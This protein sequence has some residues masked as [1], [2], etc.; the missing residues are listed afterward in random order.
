MNFVGV[1]RN[2]HAFGDHRR[3]RGL[4]LRHLL[5]PHQAHAASALQRE[6]RVVAE[7]RHFDARILAG[8]DQQRPRRRGDVLAVDREVYEFGAQPLNS[9][10]TL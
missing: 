6:I 3:A 4:Q 7:R 2:H 5:N 9:T 10:F 1:G 8:F